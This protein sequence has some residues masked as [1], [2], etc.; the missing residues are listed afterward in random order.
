M[1]IVN[2]YNRKCKDSVGGLRKVWLCKYVKYSRSQILTDGNILVLFPDT[3]IYSFHSIEASNASESMEQNEGGKFYN[4]SISL[5]FQGADP[6]E[7]ELL[8]NIDFRILYLDNNG[9]YKIFGLRNGMEAGTIAYETG[10]SKSTLNGFRITFTGKEKEE[11][12]FVVDLTTVGFIEEGETPDHF[13]LFQNED[14]FILENN[15]NLILQNG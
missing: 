2:G 11:A 4:Q 15:D 1:E 5:T 6:K 10:T 14:F 9:V 8:Q 7:I 12:V 13:L 3:F